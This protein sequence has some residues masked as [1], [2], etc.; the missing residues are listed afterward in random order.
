MPTEQLPR[1]AWAN[2]GCVN[3]GT[4]FGNF[5]TEIA[6][7]GY[8]VIAIGPLVAQPVNDQAVKLPPPTD[9]TQPPPGPLTRHSRQ[10]TDA[11]NWA[12]RENERPASPCFHHLDLAHV[13][14]IS[15]RLEDLAFANASDAFGG[16]T[17][18][19]VR[20]HNV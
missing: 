11:I 12:S 18:D 20:E 15:G 8:L 2:G 7:Y 17:I 5:L 16:K 19:D 1:G 4:P 6:S 10:L 13:A 3:D 14:Y 9:R